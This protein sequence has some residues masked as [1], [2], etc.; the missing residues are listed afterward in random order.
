MKKEK[1]LIILFILLIGGIFSLYYSARDF[2]I[3]RNKIDF[4]HN[5]LLLQKDSGEKF[6]FDEATNGR[7]ISCKGMY[8]EGLKL[9]DRFGALVIMF[10]FFTGY[11]LCYIIGLT[12]G[13]EESSK[14]HK[15]H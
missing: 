3:A 2:Q 10:S 11:I 7:I 4:A 6:C 1:I 5:I 13:F 8:M 12:L 14:W 9:V 15:Q